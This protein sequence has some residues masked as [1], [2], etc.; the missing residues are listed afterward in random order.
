MDSLCC[1]D[2]GL[3]QLK[4]KGT[5]QRTGPFIEIPNTRKITFRLRHKR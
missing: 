5:L 2:F 3:T 1:F 4:K